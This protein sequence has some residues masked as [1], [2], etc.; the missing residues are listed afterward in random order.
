[1]GWTRGFVACGKFLCLASSLEQPVSLLGLAMAEDTLGEEVIL[2][3][4]ITSQQWPESV[5]IE[6][7]TFRILACNQRFDA[8]VCSLL[9]TLVLFDYF[10][11]CCMSVGCVVHGLNN[12]QHLS[13]QCWDSCTSLWCRL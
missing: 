6:V 9:R 10:D 12:D 3:D 2:Y 7:C 5:S 4:L 13:V 11:A 8:L 1:M